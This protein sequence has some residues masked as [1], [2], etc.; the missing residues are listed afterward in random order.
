MTSLPWPAP[1]I[2]TAGS[3]IQHARM[4][5]E[6]AAAVAREHTPGLSVDAASR[7][8][9]LV[10]RSPTVLELEV[11]AALLHGHGVDAGPQWPL[12]VELGSGSAAVL[13]VASGHGAAG[14]AALGLAAA[15]MKPLAVVLGVPGADP[16]D[17]AGQGAA[18]ERADADRLGLCVL[19][20]PPGAVTGVMGLAVGLTSAPVETHAE[21]AAGDALI[22]LGAPTGRESGAATGGFCPAP[23]KAAL[24]QTLALLRTLQAQPGLVRWTRMVG[25][26]GLA[27]AAA[28]LAVGSQLLLDEVPRQPVLLHPK[29]LLLAETPSRALIVVPADR[30]AEV[31][32]AAQ[33]QGVTAAA[34]G[35][36]TGD[37]RLSA[38]LKPRGATMARPVCELPLRALHRES[39]P[40]LTAAA[41][42][43]ANQPG[44]E[45][46]LLVHLRAHAGP[47]PRPAAILHQGPPTL[48]LAAGCL[49]PVNPNAAV[50]ARKALSA[51]VSLIRET[52]AKPVGA[53]CLL[54]ATE[55]PG[56]QSASKEALHAAATD[57][58]MTVV[59]AY[60][61][62]V[63]ADAL[64]IVIGQQPAAAGVVARHF[65]GPGFLVAV[66]G[67]DAGEPAQEHAAGELCTELIHGGLCAT[68][69]PIGE[70][71]LLLALARACAHAGVG[72]TAVLP[73]PLTTASSGESAGLQVLVHEAPGRYL[74]AIPAHRQADARLLAS[75]RGVPLWPLGRTG[76]SELL[77]RRSDGPPP[78]PFT[79]VLRLPVA[80]LL[81]ELPPG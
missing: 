40:A 55:K 38:L 15:G 80:A 14:E 47:G 64:V 67:F 34:I 73:A 74:V 27:Q 61:E 5:A 43:A 3:V 59:S 79:E 33:A 63:T 45:N 17:Q 30:V 53:A 75:D 50:E 7:L 29:E 21:P 76:G 66:L 2:D 4:H 26:G 32:A 68:V 60:S 24:T 69:Q 77:I 10:G 6:I 28:G 51:A 31:L 16:A 52:G 70:G 72:C 25:A 36:V 9:A 42:L 78:S 41:P 39:R 35:Q 62:A 1:R 54:G 22:Y 13:T 48:M 58:G 23:G 71:G 46:P 19:M 56:P 8:E 12:R 65:S 44:S 11:Y 81:A 57:L 37:D 20:V 49:T 18:A